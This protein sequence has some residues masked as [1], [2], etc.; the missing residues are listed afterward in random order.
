MSYRACWL[1]VA[2][3][4]LLVG[5]PESDPDDDA[6]DDD[7]ADD[8]AA[9]DDDTGPDDDDSA[10]ADDD[11]S[12]D[13]DD[14]ADDDD[15]SQ[16]PPCCVVIEGLEANPVSFCQG[17]AIW[18]G[19]PNTDTPILVD[20]KGL[21]LQAGLDAADSEHNAFVIGIPGFTTGN[22][23]DCYFEYWHSDGSD[24]TDYSGLVIVDT[25]GPIG[26]EATGSFSATVVKQSG[27]GPDEFT[28]SGTFCALYE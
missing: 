1:F 10:A 20:G 13:D 18:M 7:A 21:L 5:C 11:D 8:D 15:D 27:P 26:Q 14:T 23:P 12:A 17:P 19:Q 25:F 9:D 22:Y 2:V 3:L 24:Y 6:D 16:P 28:L 4:F